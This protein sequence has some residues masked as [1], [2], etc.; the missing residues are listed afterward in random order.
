MNANAEAASY[1]KAMDSTQEEL[2]A[3][4]EEEVARGNSVLD[5][6]PAQLYMDRV[7][8]E[9]EEKLTTAPTTLPEYICAM[10]YIS[11]GEKNHGAEKRVATRSILPMACHLGISDAFPREALPLLYFTTKDELGFPLGVDVTM[12][13]LSGALPL[14]GE[15][16]EYLEQSRV[17]MASYMESQITSF[18]PHGGSSARDEHLSAQ[19]TPAQV[20]MN[21]LKTMAPL[22]HLSSTHGL[23]HR[24]G[25]IKQSSFA[26]PEDAMLKIL[27]GA[28]ANYFAQL[29]VL[30]R[31]ILPPENKHALQLDTFNQLS[32]PLEQ[33]LLTQL[34][35][36]GV[37]ALSLLPLNKIT[38]YSA[39]GAES[40][41]VLSDSISGVMYEQLPTMT[42]ARLMEF[43]T[44]VNEYNLEWAL[45]SYDWSAE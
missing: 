8:G 14:T 18:N 33:Q 7:M 5:T 38:Y 2:V 24:M 43:A 23:G 42:W 6:F 20:R 13:A 1:L 29:I 12:G 4:M 26:T 28:E 17:A 44:L 25:L 40:Q 34:G 39:A 32:Q 11:G 10:A 15:E 21:L 9:L 45:A 19:G 36:Q 35:N 3:S 41:H 27:A 16:R 30:A 31:C 37:E 22:P